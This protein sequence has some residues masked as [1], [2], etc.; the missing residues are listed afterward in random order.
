MQHF[1]FAMALL[2]AA[3]VKSTYGHEHFVTLGH[4]PKWKAA[5]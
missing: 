3:P 2:A 5:K 4:L 1:L